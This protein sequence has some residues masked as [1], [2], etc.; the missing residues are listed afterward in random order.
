MLALRRLV[1][2]SGQNGQ[3]FLNLPELNNM[4]IL[5][6]TLVR[7]YFPDSE[8]IRYFDPSTKKYQRYMEKYSQINLIVK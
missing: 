2:V 7:N 8:G 5:N 4:G 3:L 1:V 6:V